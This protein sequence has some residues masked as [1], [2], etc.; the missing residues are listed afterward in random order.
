VTAALAHWVRV[1]WYPATVGFMLGGCLMM[2]RYQRSALRN[3]ARARDE[4]AWVYG[5]RLI[6]RPP[7][8]LDD[9]TVG[10]SRLELDLWSAVTIAGI[11]HQDGIG[12]L[13]LLQWGQLTVWVVEPD[14]ALVGPLGRVL[15]QLGETPP[16]PPAP[17]G[18]PPAD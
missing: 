6:V 16:R 18:A 13:P 5:H 10:P 2:R 12:Q 8:P 14:A 17:R 1:L 4:L 9:P 11:D 15:D 7:G 3:W